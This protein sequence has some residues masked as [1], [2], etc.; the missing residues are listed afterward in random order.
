M[1]KPKITRELAVEEINSWLDA[2]KIFESRR[3]NF[4]D[5]IETLVEAMQNGVLTLEQGGQFRH[6]L[7]FP[8]QGEGI[9][10]TEL[11]YK[12]RLNRKMVNPHLK[13]VKPG[14]SEGRMLAH[15]QAL[16][17][18]PKNILSVLDHEDERIADSILIF[19]IS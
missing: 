2:K 4:K 5:A 19:F 11:T 6:T 13:G 17:D 9:S 16:T 12:A 8:I 7:L 1:D 3:E 18:A 15:L 10:M 14:D